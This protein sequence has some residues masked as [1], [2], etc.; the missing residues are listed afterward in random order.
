MWSLGQ[1]SCHEVHQIVEFFGEEDFERL[2]ST[3]DQLP[4][5]SAKVGYES[6]DTTVRNSKVAWVPTNGNEWLY[7][8]ITDRVNEVN[9]MYYRYDLTHFYDLQYTVYDSETF[10]FFGPHVD[11]HP[12]GNSMNFRK[13]SFSILI[14]DDYEGGDLTLHTSSG[15]MTVAKQKNSI[16][17]FPSF[18]LH[19]VTPII[20]GVRKSLVGWVCGP[21]FR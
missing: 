7:Q 9:Y 19:E 21:L 20:S 8:H 10:D 15:E 14:N 1:Y 17:F 6:D 13:L 3:L 4:L 16:V 11:Y 2:T 5:S 12:E 18:T